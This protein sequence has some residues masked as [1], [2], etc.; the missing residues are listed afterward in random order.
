MSLLRVIYICT[1]YPLVPGIPPDNRYLYI[2]SI[3]VET[4]FPTRLIALFY[5]SNKKFISR[6]YSCI[7][8]WPITTIVTIFITPNDINLLHKCYQKLANFLNQIYLILIEKE[9]S[10]C[11]CNKFG[12]LIRKTQKKE[13]KKSGEADRFLRSVINKSAS[14]LWSISHFGSP[15]IGVKV[16]ILL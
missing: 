9:L 15:I 16:T 12:K 4:I 7:K 5:W 13:T 14:L 8:Q 2:V 1:H 6:F 10:L 3:S 11:Q